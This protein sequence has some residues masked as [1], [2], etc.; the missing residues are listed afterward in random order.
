[1]DAEEV[2]FLSSLKYVVVFIRNHCPYV[3]H[4]RAGLAQLARD[5]QPRNWIIHA[6]T[7]RVIDF[8]R[9][10]AR[11]WTS[12]LVRLQHQQFLTDAALERAFL[13]GLGRDLTDEDRSVLRL[14]H[15]SQALGTIVWSRG[16]GDS[17]FEE[18]GRRMLARLVG[19]GAALR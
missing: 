4:I 11:H 7:V 17:H 2:K 10:A 5:Y 18:H 12:E 8:G 1:M 13:E 14:E 15:F 9:A 3:I 16:I 19:D 6:G